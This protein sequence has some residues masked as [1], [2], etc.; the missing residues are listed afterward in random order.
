MYLYETYCPAQFINMRRF[1][2][3]QNLIDKTLWNEE[4]LDL[5][6]YKK[7]NTTF[8]KFSL[9]NIYINIV[10]EKNLP[11]YALFEDPQLND[12]KLFKS[13]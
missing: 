6:N 9:L 7:N 12:F 3:K 10:L 13:Y 1:R 8:G 5:I 4:S 11:D 2:F